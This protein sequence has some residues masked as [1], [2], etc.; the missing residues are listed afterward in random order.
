MK[1]AA[2]L[3]LVATVVS[4]VGAVDL[5]VACRRGQPPF[6]DSP[7][8]TS[9]SCQG[10]L[11]EAWKQIVARTNWSYSLEVIEG[12]A[13]EPFIVVNSATG[14]SRFDI[15]LAFHT[16]TPSRLQVHDFSVA[17]VQSDDSVELAP[18]YLKSGGSLVGAVIRRAVLYVFSILAILFIAWAVLVLIAESLVDGSE[19]SELPPYRRFLVALQN[20]VEAVITSSTELE[21]KNPLSRTLRSIF[22]CMG[23]FIVCIFG[24]VLTSQLTVAS[25]FTIPVR[26][27]ELK[28]TRIA[29][30]SS[31]LTPYL[32]NTVGA[33]I[34]SVPNMEVFAEA[35]FRGEHDDVDGFCTSTEV[36]AYIHN[37]FGAADQGYTQTPNFRKSGT[38]ELKGLPVSRALDPKIVERLNQELQTLRE[39][40]GLSALMTKFVKPADKPDPPSDVPVGTSLLQAFAGITGAGYGALILASLVLGAKALFFGESS[41]GLEKPAEEDNEGPELAEWCGTEFG[42][43]TPTQVV[44]L[45]SI[46]KTIQE[47]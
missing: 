11:F 47:S 1:P 17:I 2:I 28:G 20:G 21:L 4:L 25:S 26:V 14:Q 34:Y 39:Q 40:G 3:L 41:A 7:L 29:T 8:N 16:I 46:A 6:I 12:N 38:V 45:D 36:V 9:A 30:A 23:A 32:T 43:L 10:M 24:A 13:M 44:L 22:A 5:R 37:K 19:L 42:C 27:T 35:W 18:K 15:I 33:T 31:T